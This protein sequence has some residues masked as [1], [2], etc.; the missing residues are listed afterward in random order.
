MNMLDMHT[1]EKANKI[2]IAEMQE[3]ARNRRLLR[4]GASI[5]NPAIAR[6]RLRLMLAAVMLIGLFLI[7]AAVIY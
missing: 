6:A 2:H 1:R 3:E 5:G 7:S 4:G